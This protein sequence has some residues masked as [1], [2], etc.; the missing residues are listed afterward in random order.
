M[1]L[2][3]SSKIFHAA[4]DEVVF[5]FH[6]HVEVLEHK[7]DLCRLFLPRVSQV[8]RVELSE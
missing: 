6:S 4:V 3:D 7:I 2:Y 5:G 1:I 8:T